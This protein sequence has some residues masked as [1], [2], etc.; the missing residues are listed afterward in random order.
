MASFPFISVR[1]IDNL[2][3]EFAEER[4]EDDNRSGFVNL[5]SD[6]DFFF[7][8]TSTANLKINGQ[9]GD[10]RIFV[11]TGHDTVWAGSGD[12][13]VTGLDGNDALNGGKDDDMLSGEFGNDTLWGGSGRDEIWGGNG[14]D[15]LVGGSG[16]DSLFGDHDGGPTPGRDTLY[17]G[18]GIDILSGGARGDTM[19]GG[20]QADTFHYH[21]HAAAF[22]QSALGDRDTILDFSHAQGDRFDLREID[23]NAGTAGNQAFTLVAGP[24]GGAGRLWIEGSGQDRTVFLN[25]DGGAADL[26]IDVHLASGTTGLV[27][28]DFML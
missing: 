27:V 19:K 23:A 14:V 13:E 24:S 8:P 11:G 28:S 20:A 25:I 16:N 15:L 3:A 5:G 1:P 22:S 10:D 21:A 12:D 7:S 6:D 18:Y 4:N 26:A 2:K 9:A 17:G